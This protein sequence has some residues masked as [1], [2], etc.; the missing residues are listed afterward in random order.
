MNIIISYLI[1]YPT[2]FCRIKCII[3]DLYDMLKNPK[4][5]HP[6]N[7]EVTDLF[8]TNNQ[9]FIIKLNNIH[10]IMLNDRIKL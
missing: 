9:L 6:D 3:K 2:I 4:I 7:Y 5:E 1:I 8:I 10:M